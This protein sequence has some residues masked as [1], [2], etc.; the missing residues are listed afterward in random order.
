MDHTSHAIEKILTFTSRL[1]CTSSHSR[2]LKHCGKHNAPLYLCKICKKRAKC[3]KSAYVCNI[4]DQSFCITHLIRHFR[5][6][7][8]NYQSF[9]L[10]CNEIYI[11]YPSE[12]MKTLT[13]KQAHHYALNIKND[14]LRIFLCLLNNDDYEKIPEYLVSM[15]KS[16]SIKD[17]GCF[18]I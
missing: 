13:P 18:F 14:S 10:C 11:N 2:K 15:T 8:K 1:S 7:A 5:L 6:F 9:S 17:L 12:F 4:C 3:F 16:G